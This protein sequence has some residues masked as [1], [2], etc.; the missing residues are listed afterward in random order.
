M[1]SKE[2]IQSTVNGYFG[3]LRAM[4][5]NAFADSF[6]QNG[7]TNDPVGTPAYKAG[8]PSE[9]SFKG[10]WLAALSSDW[11]R[12]TFSSLATAPRSSGRAISPRRT[13]AR[14][15]SKESM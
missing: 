11:S 9:S 10:F 14:F 3:A 1:P 15:D 8:T 4:D 12:T 5:A 2:T 13:V 6:A 7:V